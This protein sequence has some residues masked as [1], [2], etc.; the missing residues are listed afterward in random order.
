MRVYKSLCDTMKVLGGQE[1]SLESGKAFYRASRSYHNRRHPWKSMKIYRNPR[2]CM[3]FKQISRKSIK[4]MKIN[5]YLWKPIKIGV[6]L[7]TS[8][9][10]D[11]RGKEASR[12]SS[13]GSTWATG[14]TSTVVPGLQ[15]S[16]P[17]IYDYQ[18]KSIKILKIFDFYKMHRNQENHDLLKIFKNLL[19]TCKY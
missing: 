2:E 8:T 1:A 7:R 9:K 14:R 10:I 5:A 3:K 12:E 6:N 4:T 17:E 19:K 15:K 11:E 16:M 13:K 18:W